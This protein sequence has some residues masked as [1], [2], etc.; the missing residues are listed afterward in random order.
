MLY[1]ERLSR[2]AAGVK[3]QAMPKMDSQRGERQGDRSSTLQTVLRPDV[4]TTTLRLSVD[5]PMFALGS[6]HLKGA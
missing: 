5:R 1:T 2:A 6:C 4:L 3:T